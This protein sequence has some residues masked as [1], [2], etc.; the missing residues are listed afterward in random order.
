[1]T[2]PILEPA[3]DAYEDLVKRGETL[4]LSIIAENDGTSDTD[5]FNMIDKKLV[6]YANDTN[7]LFVIRFDAERNMYV[8]STVK[9]ILSLILVIGSYCR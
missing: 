8:V 9:K 2:R 5:Y 6:D 1:M 4:Y 7:G 3:L